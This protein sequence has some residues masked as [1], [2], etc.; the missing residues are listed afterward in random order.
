MTFNGTFQAMHR[1]TC[2]FYSG[3]S[4]FKTAHFAGPIQPLSNPPLR[5]PTLPLALCSTP[6]DPGIVE[7]LHFVDADQISWNTQLL[8]PPTAFQPSR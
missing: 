2:P 6:F 3:A 8:E 1:L 5:W 4:N 7:A